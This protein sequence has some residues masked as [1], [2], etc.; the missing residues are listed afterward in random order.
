MPTSKQD[1]FGKMCFFQMDT[2]LFQNHNIVTRRTIG[3]HCFVLKFSI[4]WYHSSLRPP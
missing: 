1:R 2:F 3:I 4:Y